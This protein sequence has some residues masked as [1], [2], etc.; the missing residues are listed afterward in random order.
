[1]ALACLRRLSNSL[2]KISSSSCLWASQ[3]SEMA[4]EARFLTSRS[5]DWAMRVIRLRLRF[6]PSQSTV[7][8]EVNWL[9]LA[10][11]LFSSWASSIRRLSNPLCPASMRANT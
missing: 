4:R 8:L 2:S 7:P 9:Y 11:S 5:G 6:S 10:S 1:M 3:E